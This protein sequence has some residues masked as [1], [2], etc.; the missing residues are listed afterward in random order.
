[1]ELSGYIRLV[2]RWLWL[3]IA[4]AVIASSAAFISVRTQP[5]VYQAT[6]LLQ[7]GN[8]LGLTDPNPSMIQAAASLSQSYIRLLKTRPILQAVVEKLRLPF[9]T[10]ELERLFE[11]Q[12]TSGTSFLTLT[13]SY[14]DP[15]LAAEVANELAVQLIANSPTELTREQQ[16]QVRILQAEVQ[17][18]QAQLQRAREELSVI[19]SALEG[20]ITDEQE[21]V[22][23]TL[24]RT[25]LI[26]EISTA[27][28]NLASMTRTLVDIQQRGTVN[29]IRVV[30]PAQIPSAASNDNPL[31]SMIAA[32]I[33]AVTL[34]FGA[35][36]L[37]EYLSDSLRSPAEIMPLLNV[38]LLGAVAPF[39][40]K[41]TYKNKLI[42]WT[43]P[44][45]TIAEAYRALRVNILFRENSA[46]DACHVYTVTS[47][48]PSEGKSVTTANLAITF[49]M[50]GMRVLLIDFD[51]RRPVQHSLFNLP[52][53]T[54]VADVWRKRDAG[55]RLDEA[56]IRQEVAQQLPRIIQKT[57][58]PNLSVLTSGSVPTGSSE[59][60]DSPQSRI[61]MQLLVQGG[62][63][64]VILIDT[65]PIL[66]VTD[67]TIVARLSGGKS[68]L[69]VESGRTRRG[70]AVR[71][72]QQFTNLDLPLLGV[73][74][75]RLKAQDRDAGYGYYYYYGYT[76]YD[77][78]QSS[79][80]PP[81]I[82]TRVND[83]QQR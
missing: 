50:T 30:E 5:A 62:N 41:R 55:D 66:V 65:P 39:G 4:A 59:L 40:N 49:A 34:A 3:M 20:L 83:V 35:A 51:L 53:A 10:A 45:S 60:I 9:G 38:P 19:D 80:P 2:R 56:A 8:Y 76:R 61:L 11:G 52:N 33:A 48:N 58:I 36:L 17:A 28:S 32:A 71:A 68:I 81:P 43:Q 22:V 64:D 78:P 21:R 77:N 75:N 57:E 69:V 27:Q 79:P 23:L 14:T 16:E 31:P 74:I 26:G 54:G 6:T 70:A 63:Y 73:V 46:E 18:A 44:R 12:L 42:T 24:R 25:E 15:V 37:L 29:F 72:A 13:V 82:N 47:P 1:M 67:T 7:L